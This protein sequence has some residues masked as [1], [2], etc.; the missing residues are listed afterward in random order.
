[1]QPDAVTLD[2]LPRLFDS[3]RKLVYEFTG[4]GSLAL[5]CFTRPAG[6][7]DWS[8]RRATDIAG[9]VVE[10]LGHEPAKAVSADAAAAMAHRAYRRAVRL[11]GEGDPPC[12]GL[13]CTATIAT[14][15]T[16]R[17]EHACHVAVQDRHGRTDYGL[18]LLKGER[19][20]F[21]EEALVARLVLHALAHACDAGEHAPALDLLPGEQVVRTHAGAGDPVHALLADRCGA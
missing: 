8:W 17:G 3:G 7:R 21:G 6:R 1:M 12:L 11:A 19:D 14:D 20:R 16:K 2:L 4:A 10:L 13:A 5:A 9:S 15:R 18:V